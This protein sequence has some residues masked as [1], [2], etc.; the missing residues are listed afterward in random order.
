MN[1]KKYIATAKCE[2]EQTFFLTM[3]NLNELWGFMQEYIADGWVVTF[4][5]S[6]V[7][8]PKK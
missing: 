2:G 5:K 1:Y 7:V 4:D 8:K 3:D 6:E